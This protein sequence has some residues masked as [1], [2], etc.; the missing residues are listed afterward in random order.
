VKRKKVTATPKVN[1]APSVGTTD[2]VSPTIP[3]PDIVGTLQEQF[4]P[5]PPEPV[6]RG[7][8]AGAK[9]DYAKFFEEIGM[10]YR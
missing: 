4:G 2:E 9:D 5:A 10:L 7:A 3:R 6:A 1:A 8:K